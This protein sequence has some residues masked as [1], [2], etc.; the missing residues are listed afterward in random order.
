MIEILL[1]V[2]VCQLGC[3][4]HW[5]KT[6]EKEEKDFMVYSK[7]MPQYSGKMCELI[8]KEPLY[9]IDIA[10][11]VTGKIIDCDEAWA[12]I[13]VSDKKRT[14]Q[15]MIQISNIHSIKEIK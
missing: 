10:Y 9:G 7:V 14:V 3:I 8:L 1:T 6:P 4:I 13:E 5:I 15:K 12:V 11:S 2:I